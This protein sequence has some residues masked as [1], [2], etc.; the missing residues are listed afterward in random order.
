M[1]TMRTPRQQQLAPT[2]F[3]LLPLSL[4]HSPN[5]NSSLDVASSP[6]HP[7]SPC[8]KVDFAL[9]GIGRQLFFAASSPWSS[10]CDAVNLGV[11]D[12]W[13]Q[14]GPFGII[15][16]CMV[17]ELAVCRSCPSG[18]AAGPWRQS[19]PTHTAEQLV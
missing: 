1:S 5:P 2:V 18:F 9:A 11:F 7:D 8:L 16:G 17:E 14:R 10:A 19:A 13:R 6:R 12:G 3:L 4:P 15:R